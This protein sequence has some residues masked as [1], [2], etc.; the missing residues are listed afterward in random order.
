MTNF[1][2]AIILLD[3][4]SWQQKKKFLHDSLE[5]LWDDPYFFKLGA[6]H[7]LRRC[8]TVEEAASILWHCHNSPYGRH[9]N[10]ER[11]TTKVLQLGFFLA[12]LI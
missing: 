2:A 7:L 9:Y 5:Y 3:D 8:V 6:D 4:L 1:K 10:G 11:T 12:N